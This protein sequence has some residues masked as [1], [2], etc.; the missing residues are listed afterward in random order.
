MIELSKKYN[1]HKDLSASL[2]S[3]VELKNQFPFISFSE[4]SKKI[5]STDFVVYEDWWKVNPAIVISKVKSKLGL[6]KR[7]FAR[8]TEVKRIDKLQAVT[9]L[10]ENHIYGS[11]QSKYKLGLFHE[12]ELVAVATFSPQRNLNVGR[13]VELVRFCSKNGTTIIGGLD[14]LLKFYE[15]E[16]QPD[17]I[18][19]YIDKDWGNGSGFLKLGFIVASERE[20]IEFCVNKETGKRTILKSKNEECELKIWN[21]GSIKFEKYC[22]YF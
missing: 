8:K 2:E 16:F 17:H 14:K 21:R 6:S 20:P 22:Y 11:V 10:N 7:I 5:T 13:S 12:K 4:Y 18:M 1:F 3:E 9:F 15:K 19:T